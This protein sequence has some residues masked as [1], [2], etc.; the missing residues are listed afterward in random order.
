MYRDLVDTPLFL[1]S[2]PRTDWALNGRANFRSRDAD[3]TDAA[4]AREEWCALADAIVEAGG[5]VLVCPPPPDPELTGMIY[6]AEAGEVYLNKAAEPVWLLPNVAAEHREGE[7]VYIK[8]FFEQLGLHTEEIGAT[9]EAQGDAIR[10][11]TWRKVVHTYGVGP[12]ARTSPDAYANVAPRLSPEHM[13]LEFDADPYFHGNTF[14]NVYLGA[15]EESGLLVICPEAVSEAGY[16][17]LLEFLG[18]IRVHKVSEEESL[19]YDT[20]ALQVGN[21]VLAPST[22]SSGTA[23]ALEDVGLEVRELEFSELLVKGGGAPVCLTCRMWRVDASDFPVEHRWSAH[24]ELA[25]H[26][27]G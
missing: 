9:W 8:S 15:D 13:Q 16:E 3:D 19:G 11:K 26:S 24:P 12:D 10:G 23:Q 27:A 18:A 22:I 25:H 6:T 14:M 20:N 7:K 5:D 1:M 17:E 4:A 2:P 21:T